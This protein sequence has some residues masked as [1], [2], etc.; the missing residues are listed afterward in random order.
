M[1]PIRPNRERA[2]LATHIFYAI[3]ACDIISMVLLGFQWSYYA[4][5]ASYYEDY[6]SEGLGT[7][8]TIDSFFNY[9]N[10]GITIASMVIFIQWF[11]RAYYNLHMV[12]PGAATMSEGWAAGAWFV[13]ILNWIRPYEIM[14]EIWRGTQ[15]ALPNKYPEPKP[16]GVVIAWWIVYLLMGFGGIAV[17]IFAMYFTLDKVNLIFSFSILLEIISIAAAVLTIQMVKAM[18]VIEDDLWHEA[19]NPSDDVFAITAVS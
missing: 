13:P 1:Y 14:M 6:D 5:I 10:L 8:E 4:D 12:N 19:Q 16:A 3:I 18:R 2:K 11:R 17:L 7:I 15:G 9:I